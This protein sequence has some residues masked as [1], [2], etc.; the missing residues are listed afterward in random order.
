[1][2]L[3][4]TDPEGNIY[5]GNNFAAG[6][7]IPGGSPDSLNNV[8]G[9]LLSTPRPGRWS[10]EVRGFGVNSGPQDYAL[11]VSGPV[12]EITADPAAVAVS[13]SPPGPFEGD[14][15]SMNF[16]VLNLGNGPAYGF[17]YCITVDN[18]PLHEGVLPDIPAGQSTQLTAD[19]TA[20]RGNHSLGITI[21]PLGTVDE[22]SRTNDRLQRNVTVLNF[23]VG[24]NASPGTILLDP[25]STGVFQGTLTNMG[26]APDNLT[27]NFTSYAP[28]WTTSAEPAR[29]MLAP[30]G[31]ASVS[32]NVICPPD[33]LAGSRA[34]L[35]FTAMSLGNCTCTSSATLS[36]VAR[37]IFSINISPPPPIQVYPWETAEFNLTVTNSGNGDDNVNLTVEADR[38]DWEVGLSRETLLLGPRSG[39]P[40]T[41]TVSPPT[42]SLAGN[43]SAVTLTARS[44]GG[45]NASAV[46]GVTVR[47]FFGVDLVLSL[48]KDSARPGER[49]EAVYFIHNLGNGPD[50][51]ELVLIAEPGW[52]GDFNGSVLL[53]GSVNRTTGGRFMV[54]VP[55]GVL[56]GDYPLQF[57]ARSSGGPVASANFTIRVEQVFALG[58]SAGPWRQVV[59]QGETVSFLVSVTNLGNGNDTFDIIPEG[60]PGHASFLKNIGPIPL[61]PGAISSAMLSVSN[62]TFP[63]RYDIVIKAVSRGNPGTVNLSRMEILVLAIPSVPAPLPDG[64]LFA[65][66]PAVGGA[67]EPCGAVFVLTAA[68]ASLM[69]VRR[70]RPE[71]VPALVKRWR[72]PPRPLFNPRNP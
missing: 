26:T 2:D 62:L 38:Q 30:Q 52:I 7:S 58:S 69:V 3:V 71:V 15:I 32:L 68:I 64:T 34:N 14:L 72:P 27:I 42:D 8:E 5:Y 51:I 1:M 50:M 12:R 33:S 21:N 6:Q 24:V 48:L 31:T 13:H 28:G 70:P 4:V 25:G 16:T 35:T 47:Q 41:V 57:I 65:I 19:W 45:V 59:F 54:T 20:V 61:G 67:W 49:A 9:L 56:A 40:L 43:L 39:R 63:G 10:V 29:A 60:L 37:Q 18:A 11:V 55:Q 22:T 66:A 17:P 53:D 44:A 36:A 46:L 23:G